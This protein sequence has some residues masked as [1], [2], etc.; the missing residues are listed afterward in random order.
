[1]RLK[2]KR[3]DDV[4]NITAVAFKEK[5]F[6]TKVPQGGTLAFQNH[7]EALAHRKGGRPLENGAGPRT[8]LGSTP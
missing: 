1:M 7:A 8:A 4:G 5:E 2:G 6:H 3:S